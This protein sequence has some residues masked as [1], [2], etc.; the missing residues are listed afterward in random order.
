MVFLSFRRKPESSNFKQIAIPLDTGFHRCDDFCK[1][2][3]SIC[4]YLRPKK[5]IPKL[6]SWMIIK[7]YRTKVKA[8]SQ[9]WQKTLDKVFC[10]VYGINC[11][12][13]GVG[14]C[15]MSEEE[16]KGFLRLSPIYDR[17]SDAEKEALLEDIKS[18]YFQS[19]Q[20]QSNSSESKSAH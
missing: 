16:I 20:P 11:F 14:V 7:R 2:L 12:V 6:S 1:S 9:N 3:L 17:L 19:S 18:R 13:N 4:I 5:E 8:L 15:T 10:Q